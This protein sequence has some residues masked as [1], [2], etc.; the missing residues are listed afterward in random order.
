MKYMP[1]AMSNHPTIV[2][3][4]RKA[5]GGGFKT[6][7]KKKWIQSLLLKQLQNGLSIPE[8]LLLWRN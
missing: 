5:H 2:T 1:S 4:I 6:Q 7:E 8:H 3:Q